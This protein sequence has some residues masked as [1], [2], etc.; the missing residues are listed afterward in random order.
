VILINDPAHPGFF[1]DES[2]ARLPAG[3]TATPDRGCD[4]GDIDLDGLPD[5][6][7]AV[8]VGGITRPVK[9]WLNGLKM[10]E[11][12]VRKGFFRDASY[13]VPYPWSVAF[14]QD[15]ATPGVNP[16][17]MSGY[18]LD[19][20]LLDIDND[21]DLDMYVMTGGNMTNFVPIANTDYFYINRTIGAGWNVSNVKGQN[22]TPGNPMVQLVSPQAGPRD[23]TIQVSLAGE[24]FTPSTLLSF[25]QGITVQSL[26]FVS[27]REVVVTIQIAP[28][29]VLGPRSVAAQ[30]PSGG[31]ATSTKLGMFAVYDA[32]MIFHAPVNT[33]V[34]D[35]M[36]TIY[37]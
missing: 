32:G 37:D 28:D 29:A 16:N 6:V 17:E 19:V 30:N 12:H 20:K 10:L 7:A 25:G 14:N 11:G 8:P 2:I 13:E 23:A 9:M 34:P 3:I 31:G 36:W 15:I 4:V 33:Q 26:R 1:T 21:G 27:P 18:A 5:I 24:N 22:R 35:R